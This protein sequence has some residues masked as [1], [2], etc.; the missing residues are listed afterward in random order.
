MPEGWNYWRAQAGS[1]PTCLLFG[2]NAEHMGADQL[3]Q[4][5]FVVKDLPALA[6]PLNV[7]AS[8]RPH[9]KGAAHLACAPVAN[10]SI[11]DLLPALS[12]PLLLLEEGRGPNQAWVS[13][14]IIIGHRNEA[15]MGLFLMKTAVSWALTSVQGS[16]SSWE[17]AFLSCS[18]LPARWTLVLAD[19][20][21]CCCPHRNDFSDNAIPP[22][23]PSS[24]FCTN[25]CA[26]KFCLNRRYYF[27]I[28]MIFQFSLIS[29][30]CVLHCVLG[31]AEP[32]GTVRFLSK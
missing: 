3:F 1:V 7:G 30:L 5:P 11:L 29:L 25:R 10:P 12:S 24:T 9:W 15:R 14:T 8:F 31:P 2:A 19:Q 26:D 28:T 13:A 20:A 23:P 21:V 4:W 27:S 17:M 6:P 16:T 22:V 32:Q 18:F